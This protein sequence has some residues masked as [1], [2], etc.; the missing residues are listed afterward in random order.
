MKIMNLLKKVTAVTDE[1]DAH[2][3]NN[4]NSDRAPLQKAEHENS[5]ISPDHPITGIDNR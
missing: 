5:N 3:T 1:K 4:Q 2:I